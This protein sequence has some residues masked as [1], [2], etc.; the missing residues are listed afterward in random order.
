MAKRK[1]GAPEDEQVRELTK[2]EERLRARE[3]ERHRNLYLGVGIAVG[4]ALLF[5]GIALVFYFFIQ[6]NRVVASVGDT[7]IVARDFQKRVLL[8]RSNLQGQLIRFQQLE[9]QF[10]NQGFFTSQINQVQA[11]LASPFAVGQQTIDQMVEEIIIGRE[12]E[13]RGITVSDQEI[14]EALREEVASGLGLVTEPQATATAAADAEAT[15][16]ASSWTPTPV[17]TIDPSAPITPTETPAPPPTRA[18]I[19]NTSYT[20][21]LDTLRTNIASVAGISLD[22]YKAV[23]RARLLREKLAE[24]I[25]QEKVSG[26][27]EQVHARHI[28]L[29]EIE[30]TP[31]L[32]ETLSLTETAPLSESLSLTETTALTKTPAIMESGGLTA[33]TGITPTAGLTGTAGLSQTISLSATLDSELFGSASGRT[34]EQAFALAAA[35]RQ[36]ILDGED[37]ATL[38][39]EYSDDPGS[40]LNGGDLDWFGRGAMV[41]PFE[42]AAF[43]LPVGEISEPISTTFGVHLIEVLERDTERPKAESQVEQERG[44]AFQT[45]L[46]EQVVAANVTRN[47]IVGN[48]PAE[49]Q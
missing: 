13:A 47:D 16:T 12:A 10:G 41:A 4:V 21:G 36:R 39:A 7:P 49:L 5:V 43:S 46:Q 20:E 24:T 33:P 48:L 9:E 14:E 25:G 15:A 40:K 42:E 27:E 28:L 17:P 19:T 37:F 35:L 1:K 8:E 32:T 44:Q 6:P 18:I 26:L 38:A 30:P 23:I 31:S 34:R 22:E 3:R 29:R 11:L 2:K 45:W